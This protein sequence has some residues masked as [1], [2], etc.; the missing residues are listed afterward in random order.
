MIKIYNDD[1]KNY[2]NIKKE[3]RNDHKDKSTKNYLFVNVLKQHN[4]QRNTK[5]NF[6][7]RIGFFLYHIFLILNICHMAQS[8]TERKRR[9]SASQR[10]ALGDTHCHTI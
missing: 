4:K 10:A 6:F 9:P 7:W 2:K 1:K 5:K 8:A 3:Y